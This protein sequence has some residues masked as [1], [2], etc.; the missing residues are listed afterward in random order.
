MRL[1]RAPPLR[2]YARSVPGALRPSVERV[3]LAVFTADVDDGAR[4]HRAGEDLVPGGVGPA[5]L[6]GGGVQ[7]VHLV[8][9]AADVDDAARHRRAGYDESVFGVVPEGAEG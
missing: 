5:D 9:A 2:R 3:Q 6:T 1:L 8:V 7:R 4:H